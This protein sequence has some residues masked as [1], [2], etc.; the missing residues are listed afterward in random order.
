MNSTGEN[1]ELSPY[2][3]GDLGLA[4]STI[5]S[6][7]VIRRRWLGNDF[8]GA[9][10][11]GTRKWSSTALQFGVGSFRYDGDHFGQPIWMQYGA[12]QLSPQHRYYE[13]RGEKTDRYGFV[14]LDR[15]AFEGD[16]RVRLEA[17]W[18]QVDYQVYG[19][20]NDLRVLDVDTVMAF[21]ESKSGG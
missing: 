3:A 17:Q 6:G 5:S 2:G 18:R 13:N 1:D 16:V 7:D 14:G 10:I 11:Q 4:D 9:L 20:D 21:F 12:T 19:T 8:Y 15:D